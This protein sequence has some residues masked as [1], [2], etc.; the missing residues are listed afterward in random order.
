LPTVAQEPSSWS[1]PLGLGWVPAA[2]ATIVLGAVATIAAWCWSI[3]ALH[4]GVVANRLAGS[5]SGAR[6]DPL[7]LWVT[8]PSPNWWATTPGHLMLWAL[9]LDR[10][11]SDPTVLEEAREQLVAAARVSPLQP[12]VRY[13]LARLDQG[14][15]PPSL[16]LSRDVLP[17]AWTG[18]QL[19]AAGKKEAAARAYRTALEI[20]A[21]A[22]LSRLAAPSFID[23]T[24]IRRYA[25]PAEELIG[26]VVRDMADFADWTYAEW[27]AALPASAVVR[28][29]AV[30]VLRERG[31]PDADAALD[32]LLADDG[33]GTAVPAAHQGAAAAVALAARAEALALKQRW[34][35]ADQQ[36]RQAIELMPDLTF[37]RSWWMNLAEIALRQNDESGRQKALEAARGNDPND[38]ITRRAVELLKYYGVRSERIDG[39]VSPNITAN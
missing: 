20:A 33:S 38:E 6:L 28:L 32:A 9:W 26:P 3:E 30:R 8:P 17:L 22:D 18:R 37:R 11:A 7:P 24:Q 5:R 39:R 14:P 21:Q 31:S 2:V 23:D 25:L 35:D 15:G 1:V 29:A 12:A 34:S 13:A 27:S 4:S 10:T 19:R 36:Y 16:A